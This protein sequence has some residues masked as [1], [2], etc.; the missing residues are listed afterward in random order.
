MLTP[1]GIDEAAWAPGASPLIQQT[2]RNEKVSDFFKK[3]DGVGAVTMLNPGG[4]LTEKVVL[5]NRSDV[6]FRTDANWL[7][8][9]NNGFDDQTTILHEALHSLT[10]LDDEKLY[11][12]LTGKTAGHDASSMGISQALKDNGCSR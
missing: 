2:E 5:A 11:T 7:N 1:G 9:K 12:L 8:G 4:V 10:G 6:Y 3:N